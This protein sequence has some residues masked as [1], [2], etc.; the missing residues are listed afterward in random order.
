MGIIEAI[1]IGVQIDRLQKPIVFVSMLAC[2]VAFSAFGVVIVLAGFEV[3]LNGKGILNAMGLASISI[4][5]FGLAAVCGHFIKKC[6][7]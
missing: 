5:F 1:I 2:F 3:M 7:Q 4:V 6:V